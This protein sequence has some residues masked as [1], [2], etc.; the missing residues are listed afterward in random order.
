MEKQLNTKIDFFDMG[1]IRFLNSFLGLKMLALCGLILF[2]LSSEAATTYYSKNTGAPEAYTSWGT[3][4]DG[5]GTA[6]TNFTSNGDVFVIRTGITM[7]TNSSWVI[8]SGVAGNTVTLQID[9]NLDLGKGDALTISSY[10]IIFFNSTNQ[11]TLDKAKKYFN[12]NAYATLKTINPYGIAGVNCSLPMPTGNF[13]LTLDPNA[14]YEYIGTAAQAGTGLPPTINNLTIS[15]TSG[16]VSLANPLTASTIT[17]NA[18]ASLIH[19]SGA[20]IVKTLNVLSDATGTGS[21]VVNGTGTVNTT[22]VS[23]KQYLG[24]GRNWYISSPVTGSTTAA[25]ST[26]S[27]VVSYNEPTATWIPENGSTLSP[28]KG[29]IAVSPTSNGAI[30][31][32]GVLNNGPQSV[33]LTRTTGQTKEGFNLVGNPYLSYVD[34]DLATKTNLEATMWYRTKNT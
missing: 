11:V 25:L 10:S 4:S 27:S 13:V 5:S 34:W 15:N 6:P 31:F 9:G 22:S 2:S 30:T 3:N 33:N 29:Y 21:F 32:T 28:M 20:L 18:R 16:A 23:V 8:G 12:L 1:S 7:S 19:T 14:N 24:A 17:I 26:A